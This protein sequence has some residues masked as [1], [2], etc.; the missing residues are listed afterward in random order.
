[1]RR[2]GR[3]APGAAE[4]PVKS[5][6]TLG[7]WE[8]WLDRN[9]ERQDGLW[10]K[11]A[12]KDSGARTITYAE[13]LRVALAYGWIDG[14][15]KRL[16]E[17]FY[18]QRFTPRRA[19]SKWS[20][21]NRAAVEEMIASGAMRPAGLREVERARADGRWDAAYDSPSTATVPDDLRGELDRSPRAA[22]AF[23]G[24]NS[25]NRYAILYRIQDAKK[26]ETRARRIA[27]FVAMLERGEK[28]HP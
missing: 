22:E 13:A 27:K 18:L 4:L 19:R 1:M 21:I 28:L 15:T 7:A 5:F 20:K 11:F 6:A 25:T 12:K 24:L 3:V 23:A 2:L 14:Q 9:H 17:R 8:R 26:P 10:V 16:D